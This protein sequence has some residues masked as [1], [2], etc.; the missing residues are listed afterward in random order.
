MDGPDMNKYD[1][2]HVTTGHPLMSKP[3]WEEAYRGA[4]ELY[5][6]PEHIE[7]ILRRG[8]ASGLRTAR[9]ANHLL[10]FSFTFRQER[11]HPLQ[12]G[13]FR[14]KLRTQRRP[15]LKRENPL[16]FYP[17]RAWEVIDTQL[18]LAACL[19]RLHRLRHRIERDPT[20]YSDRALTMPKDDGSAF[21]P[22]PKVPAAAA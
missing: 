16:V 8:K 22:V 4:W 5:Y 2:E 12:G 17:R 19:V 1:V 21:S 7:R 14:R 13:F 15:G 10:Q 6:S 3:E 20:P 18:R 11:V 9:L